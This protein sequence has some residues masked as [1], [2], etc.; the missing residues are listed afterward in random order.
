[1]VALEVGATHV[2]DEHGCVVPVNRS[3]D[4]DL[5]LRVAAGRAQVTVSTEEPEIVC[6]QERYSDLVADAIAERAEPALPIALTVPAWWSARVREEV[7]NRLRVLG[8]SAVMVDDAEAAVAEYAAVA[9]SVPATIA[10]VSL[11]ATQ[12]SVVIVTDCATRP[13]A[14]QSPMLI[15]DEGGD[16]LDAAVLR[17]L[18]ASL[19]S[20]DRTADVTDSAVVAAALETCRDV[21]ESL[22]L[23]ATAS[24]QLDMPGATGAVRLVRSELEE[25]ARPWMDEVVRTVVSALELSAAPVD[26]VLL[27]GGVAVMPLVSQRISADIGIE[28][29]L[30][31]EP[32]LVSVRGAARL[33]SA[34]DTAEAPRARRRLGSVVRGLLTSRRER[35]SVVE[36]TGEPLVVEDEILAMDVADVFAE[37]FGADE[38]RIDHDQV[39]MLHESGGSR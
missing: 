11:R 39:P 12:V 17:H 15:H 19:A 24:V 6:P 37:A 33:L 27:T 32:A 2:I 29:F 34:H 28:V 23:G 10:V 25:I 21:R 13:R 7:A 14:Q 9:G 16:D 30:P 36:R 8:V 4:R 35:R 26:A 3:Y 38:R 22:S 5:L 1:M 18:L 20:T 31:T